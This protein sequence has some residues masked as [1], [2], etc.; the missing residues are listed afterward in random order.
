MA[1][2]QCPLSRRLTGLAYIF[3]SVALT[4]AAC[5]A[6]SGPTVSPNGPPA[7]GIGPGISVEQA[8]ASRLEGPLLVNGWLLRSSSGEVLLCTGLTDSLPPQCIEPAL[9]VK[10]LDLSTVKGLRTERDTVW[11]QQAIQLLGEL[12]NGALVVSGLSKG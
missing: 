10:G 12:N 1:H 2:G 7:S 4:V 5:T 11:S 9:A 6:D 8:R 3:M